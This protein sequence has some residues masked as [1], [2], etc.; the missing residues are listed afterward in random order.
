MLFWMFVIILA[1]G[2]VCYNV[3]CNSG[4]YRDWLAAF[5]VICIIAGTLFIIISG[6]IIAINHIGVDGD[7]AGYNRRYESLVYQYENDIYDNDNDLGKRELMADIEEWN[8][9]LASR[10]HYQDNFWI[11]IFYPNI[12]DQFEFIEYKEVTE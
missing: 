2:I 8:C 4:M 6:G 1:V 7:I 3:T 5:A 12:Y 10:Q 9:D 11:G